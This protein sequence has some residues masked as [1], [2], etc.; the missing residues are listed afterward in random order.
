MPTI[1]SIRTSVEN[2]D[3]LVLDEH[4]KKGVFRRDARNRLIA[5]AAGISVVFPYQTFDGEKWAFRCWHSDIA[6]SKKRYETIS[7]SIKKAKLQFL[8]D[9]QY[10]DEGINVDGNIY[11]TIR[12]RW[13]D[14]INIKDYICRN[15]ESKSLMLSLADSFLKMA[16]S[17]HEQ[18]LAHGD[19]QH[20]N[21]LVDE[22]HQLYLVDY[23]SF[24]CP[25]LKG[26]PDTVTGLPD[27][28]HPARN[29]NKSVSEKLDYFSELVIYLSILAIAEN[30]SLVDKY[31]VQDADRL[32]FSKEDFED[33]RH[34]QI[35]QDISSLGKQF[36][37][38]L[39]ILEDYLLCKDV[40]Q[41]EP[42]QFCLFEKKVSFTS[43]AT[44]A[45]RNIHPIELKWDV[46]FDAQ[47]YL[48]FRGKGKKAKIRKCKKSDQLSVKLSE[49][50]T[51][52][53]IIKTHDKYVIK[54]EIII[55]VFD[56]CTIDFKSDKA[57]IFPS[58]P[59]KLS[60]NVQNAK[61]V[62]LD[63]EEVS[64]V[65]I[66]VVE[67]QKAATYI[68]R[69]ED[70]FGFKEQR[71][72]IQ[73]L[74]IPHVKSLLVPTPDLNKKVSIS[75]SPPRFNFIVKTPL[76]NNQFIKTEIPKVLSLKEL[77]LIV[78]LLAPIRRTFN[79]KRVI[80][81]ILS[82]VSVKKHKKQ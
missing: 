81:K 5:Y 51:V 53:L 24:Y 54:K 1:P 40:N 42:F 4:A 80:Q 50:T 22:K 41:L 71:I 79:L 57:Y 31:K 59:V 10:I 76:I 21:I 58:I 14:G 65:G 66:K 2:Q 74:P 78:P 77:G 8:C 26:E 15:K 73:M 7:E 30:P 70:E 37:D 62:W 36:Q 17:L 27:Y 49:D 48:M 34:S 67:P 44:K 68:L 20:G 61:K 75:I 47:I 55:K 46:P 19:L 11:P 39:K 38:L 9:F 23:D 69:A 45:L 25:S 43:S 63:T 12:M 52:E 82:F 33:I 60:W 32:L 18:F 72:D 6:N 29:H 28:Q 16:Q 56:E 3:V 35:Y 64:A 13:I